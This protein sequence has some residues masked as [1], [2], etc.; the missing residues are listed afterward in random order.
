MIDQEYSKTYLKLVL[1]LNNQSDNFPHNYLLLKYKV[2][3]S[4]EIKIQ[5][6]MNIDLLD[7]NIVYLYSICNTSNSPFVV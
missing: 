6:T 3:N 7:F 5:K 1:L 4:R 2:P